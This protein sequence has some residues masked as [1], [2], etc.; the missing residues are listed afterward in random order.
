M[1]C[2]S[3]ALF[4]RLRF[5]NP[6]WKFYIFATK[7]ASLRRLFLNTLARMHTSDIWKICNNQAL[8]HGYYFCRVNPCGE[9]VL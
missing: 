8:L 1:L 2:Q 4:S 5:C 7:K 6:E 9:F 3:G